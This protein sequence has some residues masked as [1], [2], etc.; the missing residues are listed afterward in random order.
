MISHHPRAGT[1][2]ETHAG[3][4][5]IPAHVHDDDQVVYVSAGILAITTEQG[6]WS[7]TPERA[8]LMP[9]GVWHQHRVYGRSSVHTLGLGTRSTAQ[10][11]RT[12][13]VVPTTPLLRELLVALTGTCLDP[14]GAEQ[15]VA[16]LRTLV[17]TAAPAG[18]HLP[19]AQDVRLAR[20]CSLAR[21]DLGVNT[22]LRALA[23][24]VRTSERTLSRLFRTEF[25]VSYP[26]WRSLV[27]VFHASIALAEGES[28]T[29]TAARY[30][31]ATP[32]AFI[33][34]FSRLCGHTPGTYQRS[35]QG[36]ARTRAR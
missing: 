8:V 32:S 1:G 10:G 35:L 18:V 33:T 23:A 7:A 3:G 21:A 16:L 4:S 34:T 17:A 29:D 6:I 2:S 22:P 14:L 19:V 15:G 30:G 24:R 5:V 12:P 36:P 9:G 11:R 26:Q 25:G 31:W 28:V 20:A 27:R 13:A